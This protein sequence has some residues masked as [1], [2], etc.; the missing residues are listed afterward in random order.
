MSNDYK[1]LGEITHSGRR[2][3]AIKLA[4]ETKDPRKFGYS[5]RTFFPKAPA[6]IHYYFFTK[7]K[8]TKKEAI[9]RILLN[10]NF[11]R[12]NETRP[13]QKTKA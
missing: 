8:L 10:E 2:N 9:N 12:Y 5:T 13:I 4:K 11:A 6:S 3:V 1:D 7:K